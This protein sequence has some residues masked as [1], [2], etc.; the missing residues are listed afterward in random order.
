MFMAI[1]IFGFLDEDF[2]KHI[3]KCAGRAAERHHSGDEA[4][5]RPYSKLMWSYRQ[6]VS[7]VLQRAQASALHHGCSAALALQSG[8]HAPRQPW[9]L[10]TLAT[11]VRY[12]SE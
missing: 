12:S 11:A 4:L 5:N 3:Q 2:D 7:M 9:S 8:G 1:E 10:S 6:Q